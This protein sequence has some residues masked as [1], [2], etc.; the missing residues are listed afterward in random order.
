MSRSRVCAGWLSL[1][2]IPAVACAQLDARV[3]DGLRWRCIG[4]FRGGRTVAAVG[5]PG[6]RH[7]FLMGVNHG[8]VWKTTDA[9]RTWQPIF[10]DQPTGSIGAI[11]VAPSNPD[12][13]YVGSGEGLQRPDLSVGDGIYRSSDGGR[14]WKHTGLSDG[15]Q[16]PALAVD[17]RNP[18][19]VFAAVLGHP[20]GANDERG[21]YR[22]TDGGGHWERVL[23]RNRD[24]GAMQVLLAPNDART[25]Y[26]VLWS[27]RQTPWEGPGGSLVRCEDSGLWKSADGGE[28]WRALSAGLPTAADGLG[29]IGLAASVSRPARLYAVLG[30]RKGG[31]LYRSEDA[32]EHWSLVNTDPRLWERDG[33]FNEVQVDPKN[34]DIVYIANVVSWK[35]SDGGRTFQAWR[36]APGGDDYHR[37]W[38]HPEDSRVAILAGDQGAVITLNGGETWSSWYNQPTAQFYHV[39]TD[40]GF[41][42]KVYGGQQE[43]GSV[44]ISSRGDDGGITLRD[45]HPVGAEEYGYVAADPLHPGIVFGG[46]L[47]RF[48]SRT[49]DVQ[50]VTPDPLR[51]GGYRW[52]RTMP[53]VFSPL[54]PHVL[55]L[56]ANVVFESRDGGQ[57]WRTLSGD[58]TR[59]VSATAGAPPNLGLFATLDPEQGLHRGVVYSIAPSP[60]R[61]PLLWAGT[62]DGLI[63]VTHNG[64]HEWRDVSPPALTPWSKVAQLEAGHFD[65]LTA[66]AAINTFRLDDVAPHA[67]RTRDG[68]TT[69]TEIVTGIGAHEIV[70]AVREDPVVNGL[71]YAATE[72]TVYVSFDAGDHWQS[73]RR[74]LPATSVRDLVVHGRDLVI[75]THGRSFW[76]LDDVTPLREARALLGSRKPW[77]CAPAPAYRVRANRNTDTPVP[78]DE[79]LGE[80]PPDGAVFD[81]WLPSAAGGGVTLEILD[82]TG[83]CFRSFSSFDTA[84]SWPSGLQV[85]FYWMRQ[86]RTLPAAAGM[87]RFVWDLH[88]EPLAGVELGFPIAATPGDT[89]AEPRGPWVPPGSYRV[90][91][92]VAGE[93]FER[94]LVIHMDPRITTPAAG[95][96]RQYELSRELAAAMR[97]DSTLQARVRVWIA[98]AEGDAAGAPVLEALS[99]L[100]SGPRP[101]AA[102]GA[103]PRP[104]DLERTR[105]QLTRLYDLIQESDS[106]PTPSMEES[107]REVLAAL[108]QLRVR[109]EQAHAGQL[110]PR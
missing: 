110:P 84:G 18:Q 36:G 45:W 65:T 61:L 50:N 85:P 29:R 87:N 44:G 91:L 94:P 15:Q 31:G 1:L 8:G 26:A 90:R 64:G 109:C 11:A 71:L 30:A 14:T 21:I 16:I 9:G 82:A 69:W 24:T 89:P 59:P 79:P 80:N 48:D 106:T 98:S 4:P 101:G 22:S 7:H 57:R 20:Y 53:V 23:F 74:N 108:G 73:L 39:S 70:N 40:N 96:R 72:R 32:G 105:S 104:A 76:I 34:P 10:D 55:Y 77:L 58:L 56:G 17:P 95:L 100:L 43:S 25:V 99:A 54:D 2:V 6:E 35:S 49:G 93:R 81:W 12:V 102:R 62:D 60:L 5:I 47:N 41:P 38:I 28:T 78:P 103:G 52:V 75:G 97:R 3:M 33:D 42:Y 86:P 27:A 83:A 67:W 92:T 107:C 88:G 51:S 63:H 68:G 37:I 13:I 46:K 66:Y 19:R